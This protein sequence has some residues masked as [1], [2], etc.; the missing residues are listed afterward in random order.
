MSGFS[1]RT[2]IFPVKKI[3][4]TGKPTEWRF[5]Q[6]SNNPYSIMAQVP[7]DASCFF[8]VTL[9][10]QKVSFEGKPY[11][12]TRLCQGYTE[13]PTIYN[14]AL[15]QSLQSLTLSPETALLQYDDHLLIAS[16]DKST[17]ELDMVKLLFPLAKERQS[18]H[19]RVN[20]S[21]KRFISWD[22][23]SSVRVRHT[24]L[25]IMSIPKPP[26]KNQMWTSLRL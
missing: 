23:T 11:T 21:L 3:R 9:W 4:A 6:S 15:R 20:S 26:T 1:V 10:T 18:Q 5:V 14:E 7:S 19:D 12:V 13:S 25:T 16:R 24:L 17:C 8:L 2:P 22:T